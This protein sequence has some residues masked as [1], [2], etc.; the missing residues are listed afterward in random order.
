MPNK[1]L[2]NFR[3]GKENDRRIKIPSSEHPY[4]KTR[5]KNGESLRQIAGDY[6]VDK[7]LIQFILY[8]ERLALNKKLRQVRG[9]SKIYYNKDKWRETMREH[10][11]Y[12]KKLLNN[13]K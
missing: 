6:G 10:R 11:S 5:Y 1:K 8:P 13:N 7:R 9:G 3:V 12:K 4:I 2:E